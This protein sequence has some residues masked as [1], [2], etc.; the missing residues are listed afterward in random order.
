MAI[1]PL[2][3]RHQNRRFPLRGD[4]GSRTLLTGTYRPAWCESK[5]T[6]YGNGREIQKRGWVYQGEIESITSAALAAGLCPSNRNRTPRPPTI[7]STA[8]HRRLTPRGARRL[9]LATDTSWSRSTIQLS[10]ILFNAD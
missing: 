4:I 2:R 9:G 7:A 3:S 10:H 1:F 8:A 5:E 6:E